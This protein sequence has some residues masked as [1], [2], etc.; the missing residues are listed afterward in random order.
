MKV[1]TKCL[2]LKSLIDFDKQKDGLFGFRSNCKICRN[3]IKAIWVKKSIAHK[4]Y[5][6]TPTHIELQKKAQQK[7]KLKVGLK[8]LNEESKKRLKKQRDN[9]RVSYCKKLIK[10]NISIIPEEIINIKQIIIKTKR[11]CK[12]L[13]N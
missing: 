12:T 13:Q 11:L 10:I 9:L 2:Q 1:C 7:H 6:S 4:K 3:N 5:I 8:K